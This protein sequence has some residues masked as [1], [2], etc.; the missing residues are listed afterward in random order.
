MLCGFSV[1]FDCAGG[2]RN[3]SRRRRLAKASFEVIGGVIGEGMGKLI[4]EGVDEVIKEVMDEV[5]GV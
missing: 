1:S 3:F 4:G 5:V 2:A